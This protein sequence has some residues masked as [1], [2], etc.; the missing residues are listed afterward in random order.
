MSNERAPALTPLGNHVLDQFMAAKLRACVY[1]GAAAGFP[2][3]TTARLV[4]NEA[5]G[6]VTAATKND[7]KPRAHFHQARYK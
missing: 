1:C 5:T 4:M 3:V 6:E 7:G 2:C